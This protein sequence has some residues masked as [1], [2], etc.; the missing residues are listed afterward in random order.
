M[1]SFAPESSLK[2]IKGSIQPGI[3]Y[4]YIVL[5]LF[6]AIGLG[7][8]LSGGF[9]PI[10]PNGPK[11]PPTLPF[12]YG[13]NG[14]DEQKIIFDTKASP[15]PDK[16][17]QLKTF[18]VNTCGSTLAI[19]F[20]ID[21]SASM[22]DD[23]KIY[24]LR[25]GLKTFIKKL[26]PSAVVGIQTFSAVVQERVPM[27][28]LKN[29]RAFVN[30]VVNGL[31]AAGWTRTKD[32]LQ[33]A[34]TKISEAITKKKF[35]AE[36]KYYLVI[37]TD[38]VPE[39][40]PPRT[41]LQPPGP[42]ADP[43]WGKDGRCFTKE[44]DPRV[45]TA[46]TQNLKSLGVDIYSVA[47]FSKTAKSDKAMQPYLEALLKEI[48]SSPPETHYFGTNFDSINIQEVLKGL[49]TTICSENIG[50]QVT[51]KP[52]QNPIYPFIT[53]PNQITNVPFSPPGGKFTPLQ[54]GAD[55]GNL[56]GVGTGY[57]D[58][59]NGTPTPGN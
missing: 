31:S 55:T 35:P 22:Q 30:D 19:D 5:I 34:A 43:L 37:L 21:T 9:I 28:Y 10:D 29:N 42:I 26:A 50:G 45:P 52:S 23:K 4:L 47:I 17:L 25:D 15:N 14:E 41:C 27:D 59:G 7:T 1:G 44:Q 51:P 39:T 36:Y 58:L 18:K 49:T 12:Y 16:E 53:Y 32:G 57:Y 33:L 24:V 48:S 13:M 54:N 8:L 20:L 3:G 11:G 2:P 46:L 40:P 56:R 6:L 38:G